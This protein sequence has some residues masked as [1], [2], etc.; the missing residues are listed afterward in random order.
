MDEKKLLKYSVDY[1]GK[2]D[3]SKRNLSDVL[4]RK[5]FRL[6]ISGFEKKDLIN[7]I[8]NII[9]KLEKNNLINDNRYCLSKI[10]TLSRSG[11]SENFI[12]N[13]LIKKGIDKN[14][15][16]DNLQSFQKENNN[17]ELISAQL[18]AKKKKLI[19]SD[20]IFEKKLAKMAR[21]G[22]KYEICK[23]VLS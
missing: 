5:I 3:S 16:Q 18:F 14:N 10:S 17:W 21:A 15:I 8:E 12:F 22:F 19:D 1:L 2:Y 9:F 13:Y 11:K 23:K 7:K 6:K 20:E 4:K